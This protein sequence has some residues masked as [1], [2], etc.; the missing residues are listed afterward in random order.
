M[1][2]VIKIILIMI[3]C[4]VGVACDDDNNQPPELIEGTMVAWKNG[5]RW[6][7][8][9]QLHLDQHNNTLTLF[10]AG[11]EEYVRLSI[12]FDGMGT[13]T[14][15]RGQGEYYTTVGGD[16]VTSAYGTDAPA[17]Q[18]T[19][20]AYDQEKQA[21]EGTFQV[22]LRHRWSNPENNIGKVSF[23]NGRFKGTITK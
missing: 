19:I 9:V 22:S 20:S 18:I 2:N 21:L 16:A 3:L 14:I 23:T 17:G 4:V 6:T 1:R 13:Y 11:G 15:G 8:T 7:G 10:G 12:E 5:D